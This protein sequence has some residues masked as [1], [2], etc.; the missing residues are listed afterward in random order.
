MTR[1]DLDRVNFTDLR[2]LWDPIDSRLFYQ[3][4]TA[5]NRFKFLLR[6]MRFDNYQ[7]QLSKSAQM[8]GAFTQP[9]P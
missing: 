3:V 7:K 5:L 1:A 8:V 9:G 2:C 4:T 6:C